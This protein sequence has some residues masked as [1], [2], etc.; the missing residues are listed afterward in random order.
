MNILI[1]RYGSICEPDIIDAFREL[2]NHVNEITL[3]IYNKE[4]T[5][6]EGVTALKNELFAHSYDFVFSVNYYPF[7][8]EVCNIFQ[9]R[10]VSWTVDCPVMELYSDTVCNPWN[11]IFLFD[12]AQYDEIAPRN[13]D[14]IF[15]LPL[16]SNPA[17]FCDVIDHASASDHA[18][19]SGDVAFVGSLYTEKCPYDRLTNASDYL[20]GYLEGIMEAQMKIYGC[21]FLEE[22]LPDSI[23]DSFREAL[24]GFYIPPERSIRN[25]RLTMAQMYLCPKISSMERVQTM[26]LLGS[27]YPV[28]LY[29][30]SDTSGLPVRNCHRV[31]TLTEMPLV[32]Y[33]S[34]INLNIT[35]KAIRTGLP[36]RIFDILSCG[37]FCLTNYQP[38]LEELFTPGSDLECYTS[39]DELLAKTEYYLTHEKDRREIAQN[40]LAAVKKYH[41]Y[42]E[43]L[44]QMISMAF[45][46]S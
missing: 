30:G 46:L 17:R 33:N 45:D 22:L 16:A 31:K 39:E 37:G 15:H 26:Q 42:P 2:G 21:Y 27:Y 19:F 28:K 10:Y 38:E 36:L 41:N 1:Y 24:P 7:I 6:L 12:K 32:F 20:T 4:L 40:G 29:T 23:V 34:K 14:C 9:I 43:R 18:K 13:P 11:R 25:D 3:E 8:S 5:P 44:L 35:A